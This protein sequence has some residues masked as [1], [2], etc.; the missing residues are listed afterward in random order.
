MKKSIFILGAMLACTL[1]FATQSVGFAKN[2]PQLKA[3]ASVWQTTNSPVPKQDKNDITMVYGGKDVLFRPSF[4]AT[5][6]TV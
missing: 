1:C 3:L 2:S 5:T 4:V 6:I